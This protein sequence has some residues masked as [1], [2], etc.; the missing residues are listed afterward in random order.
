MTTISI[1]TKRDRAAKFAKQF[2]T[3]SY[4]MGQA[5]R[6]VTD[7]CEIFGIDH[8]RL[9]DFETRVKK[10]GGKRGRIDAFIP[11]L[12]LVEMKSAGEDLDK[13]YAQATEYFHGL[14]NEE[15]HCLLVS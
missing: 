7:F 11:S 5:Q 4:E 1:D 9:L 3:A 15:C 12:L 8:R 14:K 2:E 13:A 6:F 10:S